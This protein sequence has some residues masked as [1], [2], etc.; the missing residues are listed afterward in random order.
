MARDIHEPTVEAL[1]PAFARARTHPVALALDF[2]GVCK[3][4]TDHKHQIMFTNLF[5]YLREFQRVPFDA[6]RAAYIY[7]N[8]RSPDYAGKERFRCM[9]ALSRYLADRGHD[10]AL[11]GVSR[12][13]A[14]LREQGRKLAEENLLPYAEADDVRRLVDWSR[15]VNRRVGEL[16]EIGLCPGIREHVFDPFR[17]RT[18]MF[19]VS[20]ASEQAL[21][22]SLARDGVDWIRRYLGQET[23]TKAETLVALARAGY[24]AVLMFGD[25]VEDAR[26]STAARQATGEAPVLFV[27]VIP[28]EERASFAA[29]QPVVDAAL[30]GDPDRAADLCDAQAAKFEGREAGT[31]RGAPLDIRAAE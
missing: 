10:C 22:E 12:A 4:Y 29:A 1:A 26:A 15:E 2:D 30:A 19:V 16:T 6:Y 9:E 18:D 28:G 31:G 7:I 24:A 20:T 3:K 8:F 27:P 21:R 25:S 11:P 17:E 5:L 23:A 14:A 13:V